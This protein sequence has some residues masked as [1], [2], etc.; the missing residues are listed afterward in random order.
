MS[1]DI[2]ENSTNSVEG[3][4]VS[5]QPE[6]SSSMPPVTPNTNGKRMYIVN[7]EKI[8]TVDDIKRL[9]KS[10]N[11]VFYNAQVD[12]M[13]THITDLLIEVKLPTTKEG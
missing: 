5:N 1:Q 12:P 9:M 6:D 8:N 10:M 4:E 2:T 3:A 7:W 13:V 11:L